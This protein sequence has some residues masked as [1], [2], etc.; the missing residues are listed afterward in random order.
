[1]RALESEPESTPQKQF[2][3]NIYALEVERIKYLLKLYFRTRLGKLEKYYEHIKKF[4]LYKQ[5]SIHEREFIKKD[6]ILNVLEEFFTK[7]KIISSERLDNQ[8][9]FIR[10]LHSL[11]A[12][13]RRCFFRKVNMLKIISL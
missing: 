6:D 1:M 9:L 7:H 3:L 4:D 5:L 10:N 2:I 12:I 13:K 11:H 8:R